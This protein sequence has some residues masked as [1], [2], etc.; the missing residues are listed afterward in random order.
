MAKIVIDVV[1]LLPEEI[2]DL[3]IEKNKEILK[4]D[5]DKII[6]NKKSCL[7][8]I[9]LLMGV[10]DE[11]HLPAINEILEKIAEEFKPLE[12]TITNINIFELP[13][14]DKSSDLK[15]DLTEEIEK[16]QKEIYDK[17]KDYIRYDANSQMFFNPDEMGLG[18][19]DWVNS[20][21][22]N[23]VGEKFTPHI[24]TGIGEPS[25]IE[26]K[27]KFTASKL[28]LCHLG[29]YCTCRKVLLSYELS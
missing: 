6:L 1:L 16:L 26:E 20:F 29:S 9:S 25:P 10:I 7:P 22:N 21:V 24:T 3:A 18:D 13:D 17:L 11:E 27:I 19:D 23:Q 15:L 5:Q 14:G 28:A 2:M 8:H 4:N 12:L